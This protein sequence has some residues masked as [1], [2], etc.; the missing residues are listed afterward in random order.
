MT[1]RFAL[2][3]TALALSACSSALSPEK[4]AQVKRGMTPAQV[5]AI[6]GKPATIEQSEST[7]QTLSG[8]VDHYPAPNGEGRV[9]F[10]NHTVFHAEFVSGAKS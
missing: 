6:L 4:M 1:Y 8:E 5:E 2:L 7:D 3:G 9:V 10:I